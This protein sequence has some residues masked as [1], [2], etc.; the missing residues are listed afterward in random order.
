MHAD[1]RRPL[2]RITE[3]VIGCAYTIGTALGNGFLEK[4]YVNPFCIGVHRRF[5]VCGG[6]DE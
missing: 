4:V 5:I 3:R 1:R 2:D 6:R